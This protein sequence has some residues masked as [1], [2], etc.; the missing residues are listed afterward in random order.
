M[1]VVQGCGKAMWAGASIRRTSSILANCATSS[2]IK[3]MLGEVDLCILCETIE[4]YQGQDISELANA[5]LAAWQAKWG[6]LLQT[7][8]LS[9]LL[10]ATILLIHLYFRR[11]EISQF[12]PPFHHFL[13]TYISPPAQVNRKTPFPN[14][15]CCCPCFLGIQHTPFAY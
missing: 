11:G 12:P 7:R 8:M 2:R 6:G 13:S 9:P 10:A 3:K 4:N 1:S 14:G 5:E 15:D